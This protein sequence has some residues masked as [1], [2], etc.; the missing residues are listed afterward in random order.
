MRIASSIT[1]SLSLVILCG[2]S[3]SAAIA[4]EAL[5]SLGNLPWYDS[6]TGGLKPLPITGDTDGGK[7]DSE[8]RTEGFVDSLAPKKQNNM[9]W[10]FSW[11]D[12]WTTFFW[13]ILY[14][15]IGAIIIFIVIAI[16]RAQPGVGVARTSGSEEDFSEN[17]TAERLEQLPVDVRRPASNL[18]EEARRLMEAANYNEAIVYLFSHQLVQLD[19]HQWLRLARGKTNRQYLREIRKSGTL[20][21]ILRGTVHV[22]EDAFFGDYPISRERFV[23]CWSQL[24]HFHDALTPSES[25]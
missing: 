24:D 10:S 3:S 2:L 11:S 13:V 5:D 15:I 14:I 19:R 7:N 1:V 16:M 4:N 18:L 20:Q 8:I 23:N 12:F 25:A 22:F 9:N 17:E 6:E 21:Q